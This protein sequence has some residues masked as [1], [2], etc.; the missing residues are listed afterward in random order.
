MELIQIHLEVLHKKTLGT[1]FAEWAKVMQSP[2]SIQLR[3]CKIH[4]HTHLRSPKNTV[5]PK[6]PSSPTG[7]SDD[8]YHKGKCKTPEPGS[9]EV[10][11]VKKKH[12]KDP[13]Q[14]QWKDN[15]KFDPT[16]KTAKQSIVQAH[17]WV[18]LGMLMYANGTT[19][20]KALINLGIPTMVCGCYV[21]WGS[22]RDITCMLTHDSIKLSSMQATQA[23]EMLNKGSAKLLAKE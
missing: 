14:K 12:Q 18:N 7:L 10:Q 17:D 21:L 22:C 19:T 20:A 5:P 13:K 4:H 9:L 11:K 16:L 23:K 3:N 1:R 15:P 8:S 6:R 2:R